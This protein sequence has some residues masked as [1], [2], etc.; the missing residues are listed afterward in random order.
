MSVEASEKIRVDTN[1]GTVELLN[2]RTYT[3]GST[4]NLRKYPYERNLTGSSRPYSIHGIV[5]DGDPLIVV[6]A[7]GGPTV[8]HGRSLAYVRDLLYLAVGD[9]VVCVEL[10]PFRFRWLLQTD[11]ATCFG[12][13]FEERNR[14][15]ISH[16][17]L[18]IARFS[19]EGIILWRTSGEDI[20]SGR[21]TPKSEFIEA[22]DWN[23]RIYHLNYHDG[24]EA[25][26]G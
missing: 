16:G 1:V 17:E 22:V 12:V 4:D 7:G 2:E 18:E 21:F 23:G 5:L 8:V 24:C 26:V 19:E 11:S 13:Y 9:S 6:G 25:A 20:F 14:A 10:R 15:L 3:F